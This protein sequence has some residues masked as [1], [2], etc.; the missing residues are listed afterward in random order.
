MK[1]MDSSNSKQ[2]WHT[3]SLEDTFRLLETS[4]SGLNIVE[5]EFRIKKYG[6]NKLPDVK[7]ESL[8]TVFLRQFQSP[9]IYILIGAGVAVLILGDASD[10]IVIFAVIFVNSIIGTIQE[11]RAQNTLASLRKFVETKATVLRGGREV[12][13]PDEDIVPGDIIIVQE[14]ERVPADARLIS[15]RNLRVDEASL[16]GESTPSHKVIDLLLEEKLSAP[17]RHNMIFKGTHVS[18]GTGRAVVVGTGLNTEIGLIARAIAGINSDVP[19]KANIEKLA[20][21]IIVV[22]AVIALLLF[23]LGVATG[24]APAEMFLTVVAL[25]VSI[26][27]EGLPIVL[28]LV[29]ATGVWR[30]GKQHALVKKMHAVEALGQVDILAVDK[31][32]T[33][34]KNEMVVQKVYTNGT[35]FNVTGVGY[36]PHG[37]VVL[38]G[39]EVDPVNHPE[40]LLIGKTSARCANARVLF[41]SQNNQW[42]LSGDPTEAAM[43]VLSQK[44]EFHKDILENE[45]PVVAEMPFDYVLK[46]H[47]VIHK[48]SS[49]NVMSLA[50]APEAILDFCDT[51]WR[52]GQV[53]PFDE[54]TRMEVESAITEMSKDGLR[55][56]ALAI[57][58]NTNDLPNKDNSPH[59]TFVGLLGMHDA[60][61][62]EV[63]HTVLRAREAGIRTV[64]ITGDHRITAQAIAVESGIFREGDS[65]LTGKEIDLLSDTELEKIISF[66]S[67]FARVTPEHKF[68]IIST[69]K[70][71][72]R[73]VAMTGDGVN[74]APSLSRADLGIAMGVIG[75]EVA[76]EASDIVLMD[77]NMESIISAVEEGRSIYRTIKKVI[78]YLFSTSAGE[79]LTIAGAIVLGYMVPIL[80]AQIIWLNFVTDG[81]LDTALAM[82]PKEKGLLGASRSAESRTLVDRPM[83]IRMILMASTMAIGT[84]Y[85]FG[86][87]LGDP[88]KAWT[89]SLTLLAVFQWFNAL[90]CRSHHLSILQMNPFSNLYLVGAFAMVV[91]LQMVALYTAIGQKMLHTVPLSLPEWLMII[92]IASSIIIVEELRKL[93]HRMMSKNLVKSSADFATILSN[94]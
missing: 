81:F 56:I 20:N 4:S 58:H 57:S 42:N 67:V 16:T 78:L 51:V 30:M 7:T 53:V 38:N 1:A 31:T 48:E 63:V 5:A 40:L 90:N 73:V 91:L 12:I 25:S 71:I 9:L 86:G 93:L 26:I 62:A 17:D 76:K 70:K 65:V 29:L 84:L 66:V 27:P 54:K 94:E 75:T 32:G 8:F 59:A 83:V 77:D 79:V 92:S 24:K 15:V 50:G 35:F 85:L 43:L 82:D 49:G 61:R 60:L 14:G 87:Y 74:D 6:K 33:L 34:T 64:M 46:Y 19:L 69:Y 88:N 10:S 3:Y 41:N 11:G 28:T 80:P 2:P 45:S 47:A 44:L 39:A 72:G 13:I 37:D 36:E 55:V 21:V 22:T 68:R 52:D 89:I 23:I 18:T